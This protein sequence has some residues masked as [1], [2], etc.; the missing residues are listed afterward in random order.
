VYL[1]QVSLYLIGQQQLVDFFRNQ[2][3]LPISWRIVQI[4]R[5]RRGT[6]TNTAPTTLGAIQAASQSTFINEQIYVPHL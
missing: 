6:T 2:P 4:L 1:K 5:Q 3:L